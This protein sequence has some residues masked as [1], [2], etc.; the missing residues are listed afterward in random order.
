MAG[1][2]TDRNRTCGQWSSDADRSVFGTD[3]SVFGIGY[4]HDDRWSRQYMDY[5][6]HGTRTRKEKES[7]RS[8]RIDKRQVKYL[9]NVE[10]KGYDKI[11]DI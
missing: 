7:G 9:A 4:C 8:F 10:K 2:L 5:G 11:Y 1:D 3:F 6:V